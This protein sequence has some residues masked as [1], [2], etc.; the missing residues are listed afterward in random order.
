MRIIKRL[1]IFLLK[2]FL[3]LFIMTFGICL[4]I[5]LMQFLWKYVDEMV[6]KGIEIYVLG[7]L[8]FYVALTMVSESLPLAIL[9]ASLMTFGNLGE[10]FEL[11]ALKASG[12]SLMRIMRPVMV[13]LICITVV[14]FF[15]QNDIIPISQVKMYTLLYSVRNKS[16]ELE[17][18]SGTFNQD[19]RGTSIYVREKDKKDKQLMRNVMIYD[20]SEGF[21]N[22]CVTVADSARIQTSENKKFVILTLMSGESF[23]N[24]KDNNNRAR[25]AKDAVPYWRR[26]FETTELLID[27]DGNF[28]MT[29]EEFFQGMYIGKNLAS[30]QAS[31]DTMTVKI[32][33]IKE[34]ESR[35]LYAQSY[36]KTLAVVSS[37]KQTEEQRILDSLNIKRP[38]FPFDSLYNRQDPAA[39]ATVLNHAK[40]NAEGFFSNNSFRTIQTINED[41]DIRRHHMEMHKKFTSSF[42]CL[43]FFFIGAPLGAIIRKGGLGTPSVLSVFLFVIY[44][45]ISSFGSRMVREGVWPPWE[46]MWLSSA[47]LLSLGIFLT[48]KAVNDSALFNADTYLDAIKYFLGKREYRKI[49]RKEVIMELPDYTMLTNRLTLLKDACDKYPQENKCW[50]SYWKFWKHGGS[51]SDAEKIALEIESNVDIL[52]NSDHHL[53]LN[54]T[55]DF[56]VIKNYGLMVTVSPAVGLALA[57]LFPLGGLVY[58]I[59]VYRRKI[60]RQDIQTTM[61]VCEEMIEMIEEKNLK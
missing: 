46:G 34:I 50:M 9:F 26:M 35:G 25:N 33:S 7:K 15:F 51:D 38:F 21:N 8:F 39:K 61:R 29:D 30:L 48:Y 54:K 31:I 24:S 20:Y 56:P 18:K 10:Q 53:V 11:L 22:L 28:N 52:E 42:A 36:R 58:L 59:A 32:D 57:L 41:K 13:F 44:Y 5:F 1:D 6:G 47:V 12:I 23:E 16:P 2:T 37:N 4:F 40:R 3:P 49:E 17:I 60:L 43:V 55:M 19:M 14:A 45:V 27:F